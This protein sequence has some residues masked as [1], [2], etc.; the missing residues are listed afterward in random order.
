MERQI[1]NTAFY[2]VADANHFVGVVGLV[3]S[4]RLAGHQEQ[5]YVTDCGLTESQRRRLAEHVALVQAPPGVQPHLVKT[6]VPLAHP[7]DVMI[8]IDADIIVTRALCDL[9][10]NAAAGRLVAFKDRVAHRFDERWSEL[11]G[12]ETLR[13]QSYVNNGLVAVDRSLGV[14]VLERISLGCRQID[15]ALG[16]GAN[17][18][19]GYPFYFLD[20]D[21][22]NAV[23]ATVAEE[24]LVFLDHELAPFP[25]FSGLRLLDDRARCSYEGGREPY[26]LHHVL[27]KP[28]LAATRWN[29]YSELLSRLLLS[30]DVALPLR[31]EEVPLRLRPGPGAW[32]EKRRSD[33]VAVLG[34]TRGR[35][36]LRRALERRLTRGRR[37]HHTDLSP[38]D[39]R[40]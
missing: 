7:T 24:K 8:L 1:P 6:G 33:M 11:L 31:R 25:P 29:I 39:P 13:R 38:I 36:G 23:I 18:S 3:N 27:D 16:Y 2:T 26:L 4:L 28:W 30:P 32:L 12:L 21:V 34:R 22:F 14:P 9:I 19:S 17:G 5:I 37:T 10:A 35:L 20:Q 15:P 40:E